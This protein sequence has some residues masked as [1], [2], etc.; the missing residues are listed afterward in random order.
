MRTAT[1][2]TVSDVTLAEAERV[3][4][5][6]EFFATKAKEEIVKDGAFQKELPKKKLNKE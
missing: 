4:R 6:M 2:Y 5:N 3:F 1:V